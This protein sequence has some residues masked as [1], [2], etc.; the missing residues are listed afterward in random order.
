[1]SAPGSIDAFHPIARA[2]PGWF[3]DNDARL[4]SIV[5]AA[6]ATCGIRGD[7][8]EIGAFMGRSAAWLATLVEPPEQLVISDLF[9]YAENTKESVAWRTWGASPKPT[10]RQFETNLLRFHHRL[11]EIY[12]GPSRAL[13]PERLGGRRFRIVHID[14]AHDYENVRSDL[15]LS[16]AVACEGAVIALDDVTH[17]LFPGVAAAVW[18]LIADGTLRPIVFAKKLY[19]TWGASGPVT[20]AVADLVQRDPHLSAR[21]CVVT[22]LEALVVTGSPP[23]SHSPKDVARD[24]VPPALYRA[25]AG[26]RRRIRAARSR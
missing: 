3:D 10:R 25:A 9:Q 5:A 6:Q 14:G 7:I 18:P 15:E 23:S 13:T 12:E 19:A 20:E 24:W 2:I 17:P 1:M 16:R 8:L 11:P 26:A 21:S 4:F 22:D